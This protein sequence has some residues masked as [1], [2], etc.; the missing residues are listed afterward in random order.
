MNRLDKIE[1]TV[2]KVKELVERNE[3]Y[4]LLP[5][6]QSGGGYK[7]SGWKHLTVLKI[8]RV[9]IL[10]GSTMMIESTTIIHLIKATIE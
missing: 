2:Q 9:S 5:F 1:D 3:N 7:K 10:A 4:C 6:C 8:K